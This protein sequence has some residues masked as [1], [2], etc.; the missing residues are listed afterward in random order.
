SQGATIKDTTLDVAIKE[1]RVASYP[2]WGSNSTRQATALSA[3]NRELKEGTLKTKPSRTDRLAVRKALDKAFGL[4][5]SVKG[6]LTKAFGQ[7][8]SKTL[9]NGGTTKGTSILAPSEFKVRYPVG[10]S[11]GATIKDTTLDVAIKE[12]RVASYPSWGS[13]ST[14]PSTSPPSPKPVNPVAR[15]AT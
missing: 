1:W 5:S 13:N 9:R 10:S 2:S 8:G 7:D 3:I 4:P 6:Q 15:V 14:R 11:Q 12:W